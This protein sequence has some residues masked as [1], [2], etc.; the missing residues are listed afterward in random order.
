[1][2]DLADK[3]NYGIDT[4]LNNMLAS[5]MEPLKNMPGYIDIQTYADLDK[6]VPENKAADLR[7]RIPLD[8]RAEA[9]C[10]A[11]TVQSL[12]RA[13]IALREIGVALHAA[14]PER[15]IVT[16]GGLFAVTFALG[17]MLSQRRIQCPVIIEDQYGNAWGLP[18]HDNGQHRVSKMR[19][20]AVAHPNAKSGRVAVLI[21]GSKTDPKLF[22]DFVQSPDLNIAA[23]G[24]F[25]CESTDPAKQS[26]LIQDGEGLRL[27]E[28]FETAVTAFATAENAYDIVLCCALGFPMSVLLGRLFNKYRVTCYDL[29]STP[30][31]QPMLVISS[32]DAQIEQICEEN[33]YS[34]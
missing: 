11:Q 7:I 8:M 26:A 20:V 5:R 22:D 13:Q 4:Y 23:A 9:T 24:H 32:T 16:G 19:P 30:Q 2:S 31:Y 6:D 25:S 3:H 15:I 34:P 14:S 21:G 12:R 17:G 18:G 33:P 28:E 29:D 1:M 27:A 10:R